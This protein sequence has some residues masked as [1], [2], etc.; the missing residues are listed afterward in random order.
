VLGKT[1]KEKDSKGRTSKA[2]SE[3]ANDGGSDDGSQA[4][5]HKELRTIKETPAQVAA[6]ACLAVWGLKHENLTGAQKGTYYAAMNKIMGDFEGGAEQVSA[7]AAQAPHGTLAP[8]ARPERVIPSM[9]RKALTAEDW[10]SA[11]AASRKNGVAPGQ[12][13]GRGTGIV[14]NPD[15]SVDQE[16]NWTE[17][18]KF[19][20]ALARSEKGPKPGT[21]GWDEERGIAYDSDHHP[22]NPRYAEWL[23]EQKAPPKPK[24]GEPGYVMP[25]MPPLP[26]LKALI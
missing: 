24:R 1:V 12:K 23:E 19:G 22:E 26:D 8:E 14:T 15:G 5:Q 20:V 10:S 2:L 16:R 9:V 18:Q 4:G 3:P 11:F 6:N 7:W 13:R 17:E 21:T 25:P